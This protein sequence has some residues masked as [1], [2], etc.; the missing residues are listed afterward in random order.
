MELLMSGANGDQ[1]CQLFN[2]ILRK[3]KRVFGRTCQFF[4]SNPTRYLIY[5]NKTLKNRAS[6]RRQTKVPHAFSCL[7]EK[8][9]KKA[10]QC[11]EVRSANSFLRIL[12]NKLATGTLFKK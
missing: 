12:E 1:E 6:G 4:N 11:E 5:D 8:N 2:S 3:F 7:K 9:P 10:K